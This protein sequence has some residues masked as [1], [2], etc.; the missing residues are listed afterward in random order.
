MRELVG[1]ISLVL[2]D[3]CNGVTDE[4]VHTVVAWACTHLGHSGGVNNLFGD[5]TAQSMVIFDAI[6]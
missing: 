5:S 4:M 2:V 6:I 1:I 3:D